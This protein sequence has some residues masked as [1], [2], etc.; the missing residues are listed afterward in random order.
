M[1]P[2]NLPKWAIVMGGW[3]RWIGASCDM[4][5]WSSEREGLSSRLMTERQNAERREGGRG[6]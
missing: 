1:N 5:A 4:H 6:I 2:R 3:K